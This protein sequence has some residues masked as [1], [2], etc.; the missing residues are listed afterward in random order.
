MH[1]KAR[2][3]SGLCSRVKLETGS[4]DPRARDDYLET[5]SE[6]ADPTGHGSGLKS[7]ELQ[8]SGHCEGMTEMKMSLVVKVSHFLS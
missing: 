6:Q 3:G 5:D 4:E 8:D 1:V 7:Q 2:F